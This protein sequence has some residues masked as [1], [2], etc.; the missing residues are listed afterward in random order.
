MSTSVLEPFPTSLL[1]QGADVSFHAIVERLLGHLTTSGLITDQTPG[2]VARTFIETF[3]RELALFYQILGAA[4]K[5]G[6]LETA[7]GDALDQVVALLGLQRVKAGRLSG[8]VLFTRASPAAQDIAIP[9]GLR[10]AG[11]SASP[12]SPAPLLEVVQ[13]A[14]LERGQRSVHVE[15]QEIPGEEIPALPSVPPGSITLMPRPLLGIDS[16]TN[17]DAITRS[18]IDEDDASLRARA[19]VALR[20][21][22]L[23]TAEAIEAAVRG[24]G[25]TAVSVREPTDGPPGRVV[26]RIGDINV[27]QSVERWA[28]VEA[29]VYRA[30]AAGVRV[31]FEKIHTVAI[32]PALEVT[33]TDPELSPYDEAALRAAIT[34]ALVNVVAGVPAGGALS[35]RKLEGAVLALAD[36]QEARILSNTRTFRLDWKNGEPV[37]EPADTTSRA[38]PDGSGWRLE[39]LEQPTLDLQYW[40][41]VLTFLRGVP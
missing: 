9:A 12:H 13:E 28:A 25:V 29:A 6:Y 22:E 33:P 15:V 32:Q 39:E 16:V 41:P 17:P 24:Q 35:K 31:I 23:A 4:H 3:A 10:V 1:P 37:A 11:K 8:R 19:R 7:E 36:V 40:P 18:G 38:L 21:G 30:K 2:G 26:V 27:I 34:R 14:S 20:A 5:A